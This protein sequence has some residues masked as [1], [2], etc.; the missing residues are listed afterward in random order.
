MSPS[1]PN[2]LQ[3]TQYLG[4]GGL[5]R[6]ILSLCLELR[7]NNLA[8]PYI[9]VYDHPPPSSYAT[10]EDEF[11]SNSFPLYTMKKRSGF[12]L[13][14]AY[15]LIK[16]VKQNHIEII[17]THHIGCLI[18]ALIVK[19]VVLGRIKVILTQHSFIHLERKRRYIIYESL[20]PRLADAITSVSPGLISTFQ[21]LGYK[22]EM[23]SVIPNGVRTEYSPVLN[24]EDRNTV[25]SSLFTQSDYSEPPPTLKD[26]I[27][28]QWLLYLARIFPGKGQEHALDVWK[29]LPTEIQRKC[30]LIFVG[31]SAD[32]AYEATLKKLI[33]TSPHS[34]KICIIPGTRHPDKWI[35]GA[36]IFFSCSEFEG[37]PLGPLE[38]L[39]AGIPV[40]L[41]NIPGHRISVTESSSQTVSPPIRPLSLFELNTPASAAQE[42]ENCLSSLNRDYAAAKKYLW[43]NSRFLAKQYSEFE[44]ASS[45]SQ[46]YRKLINDL[47]GKKNADS[48]S[49]GISP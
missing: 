31:L 43:E 32:P 11:R 44:M 5:E 19:L 45:Y 9:F 48:I 21:M 14:V 1:L 25:R 20:F 42:I 16:F 6:M 35:R 29:M 7:K 18:Y 17:H 8:V 40:I 26:S 22:K 12:S 2:V 13:K 3:L 49:K 27:G 30:N 24:I 10:L 41:S 33:E 39:V 15:E 23:I 28:N 34:E 36:D 47:L 38:A 37:M 46:L 4:I